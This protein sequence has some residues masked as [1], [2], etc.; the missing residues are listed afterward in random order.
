MSEPLGL[1]LWVQEQHVQRQVAQIGHLPLDDTWTLDY[2][3]EWQAAHE[4]FALSPAL[5]LRPP[6][7]GYRSASVRRFLENLLPEGRA[8]DIVASNRGV[9]K[10]NIYGLI[11]ALGSETTG[12]FRFLPLDV[13]APPETRQEPARIVTLAELD[14]RIAQR[15]QR[16]FVEWDGKVRMSI[17]GY[18][19]KLPVFLQG[20]PGQ[21]SQIL[22]PEYP[23][24]ST[25]LLKPQ[26]EEPQLAHMVI[27]E[28]YCMSLAARL[29]FPVA[30][31]S[32]LR[33]PRPVLV[34]KRFDR[35]VSAT[36]EGTPVARLHLIDACQA[37]D[38]PVS[39]KYE[40]HIGSSPEVAHLRDGVSFP[41]LFDQL[42]HVTRK[43]TGR[44]AMLRWSL[45][46]FVIGNCDAHGKNFSFHV[47]PSGLST[48]PWYD[49]VSV[50]Q[51]P[52]LSH[53]LAMAYGDEF[54]IDQVKAFALAEFAYRAGI[55]RQ[56]L[57]RESK[58]L[59]EGLRTQAKAL[60]E[61]A[62]Y[63]AQE[64]DFALQIAVTCL[65]QAARL[66]ATARDAARIS[67]RYLSP[68]HWPASL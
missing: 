22:L 60:A 11:Q 36:A 65:E 24:A 39:Y 57:I 33:T 56:L 1:G 15:A 55:D 38:L 34:V 52:H 59:H 62:P 6:A 3:P 28:H 63:E 13:T 26:P 12:A 48:A 37:A 51:Y 32:L 43:A 67:A 31:V 25:H 45:F 16:P 14:Q 41:L 66:E 21:D 61:A 64:R 68:A 20:D 46:N 10:S 23:L 49:L 2:S 17:A 35:E 50:V 18:Q 40:R 42:R 9:A 8:L 44:L 19:D 5:P 58:R 53:E 47:H 7:A 54:N 4:A 29:G 30:E 27:N